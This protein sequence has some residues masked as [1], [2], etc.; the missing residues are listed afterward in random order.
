MKDKSSR[1]PVNDV[2]MSDLGTCI[3]FWGSLY[4]NFIG[5]VIPSIPVSV[6]NAIPFVV[7]NGDGLS[8]LV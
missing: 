4:P 6:R 8:V 2:M 3:Y 5:F 7:D 1:S